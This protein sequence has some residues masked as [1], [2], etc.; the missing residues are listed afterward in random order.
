MLS[1]FHKKKSQGMDMNK[2]LA[3]SVAAVRPDS[4]LLA[5]LRLPQARQQISCSTGILEWHCQTRAGSPACTCGQ[6]F[7]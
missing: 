1:A 3:A 4:N 7:V 5:V 6:H 2:M